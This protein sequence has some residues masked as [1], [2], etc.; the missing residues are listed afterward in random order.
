[1]LT[2]ARQESVARVV[3]A[4]AGAVVVACIALLVWDYV[5]LR[6]STPHDDSRELVLEEKVRAE[7]D[8]SLEL[9]AERERQTA[10]A[11]ARDAVNETIGLV[12]LVAAA[13]FLIGAKWLLVLAGRSALPV[14]KIVA[15]RTTPAKAAAVR[16]STT[17]TEAVEP[18]EIDLGFVDAVVEKEGG[19]P[20]A[21][22]PI[23]RAI[24]SHYGY[25]PDEAMRRLCELTEIT[26][27]QIAGTSSFYAQFRRSA[28]GKHLVRICRGTACHV[29]GIVQVAEEIRRYLDVAPDGDTDPRRLFTLEDVACLGCCSLAPVMMIDEQTVGKLT[30]TAA[31]EALHNVEPE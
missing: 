2:K 29:T 30:P 23:L 1:M 3:A 17:S 28:P 8:A 11:L 18:P 7:A 26:P 12:L 6:R 21:A 13:A 5:E 9:T 16:R 14:E 22:I 4:A 25:L 10:I 15:L 27:A 20:E 19:G 24:Q 31:C